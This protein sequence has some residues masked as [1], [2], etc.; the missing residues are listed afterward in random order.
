MWQLPRRYVAAS[1][2]QLPITRTRKY[3]SQKSQNREHSSPEA[4]E[5]TQSRKQNTPEPWSEPQ[6][7]RSRTQSSTKS[8]G[9]HHFDEDAKESSA[10]NSKKPESN[11]HSAVLRW[12]FTRNWREHFWAVLLWS[13]VSLAG[14]YCADYFFPPPAPE[15]SSKDPV[16][17][18]ALAGAQ[19]GL[20]TYEIRRAC[21]DHG[22]KVRLESQKRDSDRAD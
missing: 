5:S 4:L 6:R 1:P 18:W 11:D 8:P 3:S 17:D 20:S 15:I 12:E 10:K 7:D 21:E 9:E 14:M 16:T 22:R 2:W 13:P 19:W